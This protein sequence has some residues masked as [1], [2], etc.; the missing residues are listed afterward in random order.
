[1]TRW[2][3]IVLNILPDS[4]EITVTV[5]PNVVRE[6]L[7]PKQFFGVTI[8]EY[9]LEI[10]RKAGKERTKRRH[11]FRDDGEIIELK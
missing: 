9:T 11:A 2:P 6:Q 3:A 4:G 10:R 5:G 8:G 7:D 1:M